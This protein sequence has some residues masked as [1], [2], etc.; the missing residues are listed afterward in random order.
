MSGTSGDGIDAS[1]IQS[2]GDNEYKV[3][4]DQYFKYNENIYSNIH[5]LK[6]KINNLKDLKDFDQEIQPIEKEIT[7]FHSKVVNEISSKFDSNI[8][9]IGFHGQTIYHNEKEK[10]SKQLG[11]GK[12]LSQLTK[13]TVIY[14]FRQNDLINGGNGAPLS[15]IF[16]KI[17]VNQ[18]KIKLPVTILNLG[19]VANV[20]NL[21]IEN[22]TSM[23][24]ALDVGPGNCLID[25]WIRKNSKE[26]YDLNGSLAKSGKIQKDILKVGLNRYFAKQ[27]SENK[28]TY[29]I[30]DFDLSFVNGLS[31]EDGAATLTEFT[32]EILSKYLYNIKNIVVCGGGRKNLFLLESIKKR[33]NHNLLPIEN[34]NIDGDFVESQAFAFLAI[35]SYLKLPISFPTTTGV[36]KPCSGGEIIN[37]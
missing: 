5:N 9:F 25:S 36:N 29:D 17:M 6:D 23:L 22:N 26:N 13:K 37:N 21:K 28:L 33:I 15:P 20:T 24:F 11:N 7:L 14:N 27:Q 30:K 2:D 35:R 18:N 31:L 10:V 1:I 16:H 34:Y 3:I 4:L 8:D 12:L 32:A 19:G